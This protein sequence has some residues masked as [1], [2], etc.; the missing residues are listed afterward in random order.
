MAQYRKLA[1]LS[2]IQNLFL[3]VRGILYFWY[4]RQTVQQKRGI[5]SMPHNDEQDTAGA[6]LWGK[7]RVERSDRCHV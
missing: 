1:S 2:A 4:K 6:A 3:H 5:Y 7:W